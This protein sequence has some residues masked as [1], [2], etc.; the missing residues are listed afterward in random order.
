MKHVSNLNKCQHLY[1]SE[2]M[3]IDLNLLIC[4]LFKKT[5]KNLLM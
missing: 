2:K 1:G 3:P 4:K 5:I